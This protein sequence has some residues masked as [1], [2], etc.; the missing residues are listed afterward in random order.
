MLGE[1]GQQL[2]DYVAS[3]Q[4]ARLADTST[5]GKMRVRA[6]ARVCMCVCVSTLIWD[7]WSS[8]AC[9]GGGAVVG[10][11][12]PVCP[13]P[14]YCF[15]CLL[16]HDCSSPTDALPVQ[17]LEQLLDLW[18]RGAGEA[19]T[20]AGSSTAAMMQLRQKNKASTALAAAAAATYATAWTR[21]VCFKAAATAESAA[22]H[23]C[24]HLHLQ[25]LLFSN[26]VKLLR[27]IA[28]MATNKGYDFEQLDG[29]TASKVRR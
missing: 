5:C 29:S 1:D 16:S 24:L 11:C 8:D 27:I 15:S 19:E 12:V 22:G 18:Y 17:A 10:Q 13:R 23:P 3:E 7:R 9:V 20:A 2:G 26:S 4:H 21:A 14:A 25:V 6:C 28:A